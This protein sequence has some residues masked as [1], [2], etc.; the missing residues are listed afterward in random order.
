MRNCHHALWTDSE[1]IIFGFFNEGNKR[2][3]KKYSRIG[4]S[5]TERMNMTQ[6]NSDITQTNNATEHVMKCSAAFFYA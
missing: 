3:Y 4:S 1:D 2:E 5:L 6:P